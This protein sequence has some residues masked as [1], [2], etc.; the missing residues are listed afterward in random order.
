MEWTKVAMSAIGTGAGLISSGQQNRTA[1]EIKLA[2]I[3]AATTL[4]AERT[5]IKQYGIIAII[6][7]VALVFVAKLLK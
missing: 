2:N 7:I 4:Q 6:G 1:R 3:Q 5:K